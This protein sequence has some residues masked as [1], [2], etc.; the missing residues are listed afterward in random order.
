MEISIEWLK[1]NQAPWELVMQHWN[2]TYKIRHENFEK[3]KERTLV[4]IFIEWPILKHP[5]GH[6]LIIEHFKCMGLSEETLTIDKWEK[7]FRVFPTNQKFDNNN[8][9]KD[10]NVNILIETLHDKD[11]N[12]DKYIV[13]FTFSLSKIKIFRSNC[14]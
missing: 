1:K 8:L 5:N 4:N 14:F 13:L 6:S 7:F 10:D 2:K 12:D 9:Y 3:S 11:I